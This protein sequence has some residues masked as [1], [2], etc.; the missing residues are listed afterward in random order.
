MKKYSKI[1]NW[2]ALALFG[3]ILLIRNIAY[4]SNP[5]EFLNLLPFGLALI[6]IREGTKRWAI[7]LALGIN[8][9]WVAILALVAVVSALGHAASPGVVILFCLI[10]LVPCILNVKELWG[11]LKNMQQ[12]AVAG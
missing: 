3:T 4:P 1:L 7:W 11:L 12:P 6:A 5:L 8:C 9:L 2:V 10:V